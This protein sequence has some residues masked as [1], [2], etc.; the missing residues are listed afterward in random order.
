MCLWRYRRY[1]RA[2]STCIFPFSHSKSMVLK[3]YRQPELLHHALPFQEAV[4]DPAGEGLNDTHTWL[5]WELLGQENQWEMG[6]VR[7]IGCFA[8]PNPSAVAEGACPEFVLCL[9]FFFLKQCQYLG[10]AAIGAAV[11]ALQACWS[12]QQYSYWTRVL[13]RYNW[14][15]MVGWGCFNSADAGK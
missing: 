5:G 8:I 11:G 13:S 1:F 2:A 9:V 6:T 10:V 14:V 15:Y 3:C 12:E 7:G 4:W